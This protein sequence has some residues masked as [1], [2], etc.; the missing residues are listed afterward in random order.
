ML[1]ENKLK[2]ANHTPDK[3][4]DI[5]K[6]REEDPIKPEMLTSPVSF[7]EHM[8]RYSLIK[9]NLNS[10]NVSTISKELKRNSYK[11][12]I[13]NSVTRYVPTYAN[14]KYKETSRF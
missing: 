3:F 13:N 6:L 2:K 4:I 5:E 8:L 12:G 14:R 10:V 9:L 7:A 1:K 11:T